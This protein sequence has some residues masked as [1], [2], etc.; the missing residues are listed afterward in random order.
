MHFTGE[1][2]SKLDAKGRLV[3]PA[4]LKARLPEGEQTLV[5]LRGFEPCLVL[6]PQSAWEKIYTQVTSLNEFVAENR[7]FQ[8]TFLRGATECD[9]DGQ[10]RILIPKSMLPHAGLAA[11]VLAVGVGNRIELWEPARYNQY[12]TTDPAVYSQSAEKIL[13]DQTTREFN[14][15]V[16]RN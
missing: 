8:R 2:E 3:L 1:H 10:G 7:E 12:L 4:R 6:Y 16:H 13:G 14:F 11:D 15:H 9:L 5:C